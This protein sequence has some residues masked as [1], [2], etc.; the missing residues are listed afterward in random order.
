MWI[1]ETLIEL[2]EIV[3]N[4]VFGLLG[5]AIWTAIFAATV[6]AIFITLTLLRTI[7]YRLFA[8]SS[9]ATDTRSDV[10][11]FPGENVLLSFI[12]QSLG[13]LLIASALVVE[14]G[15]MHGLWQKLKEPQ[16][17]ILGNYSG[18]VISCLALTV[19]AVVGVWV[20]MCAGSPLLTEEKSTSNKTSFLITILFFAMVVG[21]FYRTPYEQ[22]SREASLFA[23]TAI[24]K[25]VMNVNAAFVPH[26]LKDAQFH[27]ETLTT[28]IGGAFYGVPPVRKKRTLLFH[29]QYALVSFDDFPPVPY[30]ITGDKIVIPTWQTE[31]ILMELMPNSD[32]SQLHFT[33]KH[34]TNADMLFEDGLLIHI[35]NPPAPFTF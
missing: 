7:L 18:I 23:N 26:E 33:I 25:V 17:T 16:L 29:E 31:T 24:S 4:A 21:F 10:L 1:I 13:T 19:T 6:A 15:A 11:D 28:M 22:V 30:H 5:T 35:K 2:L 14:G 3:T 9:R 32:Y 34:K 12:F 27:G 8:S 20:C